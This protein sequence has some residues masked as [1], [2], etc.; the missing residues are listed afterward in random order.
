[1]P[2]NAFERMIALRYLRARRT[3]GFV[4]V[5][6]GFCVLGIGLGVATLIVVMA[7]MNGFRAELVDRILGLNGHVSV[8]STAGTI[9]D[10]DVLVRQMQGQDDVTSAVPVLEGQ[11]LAAV[12]GTSTFAL[13]RGMRTSDIAGRQALS[14]AV[15]E[16]AVSDVSGSDTVMIGA[17]MAEA[18]NVKVGEGVTLISP[19]GTVTAFGTV[20]R[21]KLFTVAAVFEVGMFEYDSAFV[22]MPLEAAQS[23]FLVRDAVTHLELTISNPENPEPVADAVR[24]TLPSSFAVGTWQRGNAGFFSALEVQRNVMA[25]ILAMIILVAAFNIIS[26]LIMMVKDKGHDIAILRTMGATRGAVMRVFFMSGAAVGMAG[27]ALGVGLGLLVALNI[28]AIRR[29]LEAL[30][31]TELFNAKIYYLTRLP[32]TVEAHEVVWVVLLALGLS[33]AATLY[34]AWR[35]ARLDP[36]EALRYE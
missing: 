32:A 6:A 2:F 3:E 13:V 22:F 19:K 4:S 17:R 11:V 20:P 21:M 24:E 35:A 12:P 33:F 9:P 26:G 1:M 34:P 14:G 29:F 30:T 10:Y 36:V 25:L 28:E 7:V 23:F 8:V 15:V 18:L 31:G 27:T 16:G 5:I